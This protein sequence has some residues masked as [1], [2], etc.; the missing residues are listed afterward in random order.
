MGT[1][2]SIVW[3]G[4]AKA[5]ADSPGWPRCSWSQGP[6]SPAAPAAATVP[7]VTHG[8]SQCGVK[9]SFEFSANTLHSTGE[10][11]G[12]K[13]SKHQATTE[14]EQ[15]GSVLEGSRKFQKLRQPL[16]CL[17]QLSPETQESSVAQGPLCVCVHL[18]PTPQAHL[19]SPTWP[20]PPRGAPI[21]QPQASLKNSATRLRSL[22]FSRLPWL[23]SA[24]PGKAPASTHSGPPLPQPRQHPWAPFLSPCPHCGPLLEQPP[25]PPCR[26]G[27]EAGGHKNAQAGAPTPGWAL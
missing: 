9:S 4:P 12:E 7:E 15:G 3:P 6:G 20:L 19:P 21:L 1:I 16:L 11:A 18:Q 2:H 5:R 13:N 26:C 10:M 17:T 25:H 8:K 23:P 27:L 22:P 14:A 24:H